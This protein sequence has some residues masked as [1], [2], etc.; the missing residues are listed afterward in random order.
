MP[1]TGDPR[2]NYGFGAYQVGLSNVGSYQVSVRPWVE[3]DIAVP[4]TGAHDT[5]KLIQFPNVTKFVTIRNDGDLAVGSEQVASLKIAF[6][7]T[8]IRGHPTSAPHNYITLEAS[9]SFSADFKVTK[10][11]LMATGSATGIKATVIAGLTNIPGASLSGS[12]DGFAGT[13]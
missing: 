2:N 12:W 7:Q 11:Y 5:A 4:A 1:Q 3:C 10:L 9:Q 13:E 6:S 8:G